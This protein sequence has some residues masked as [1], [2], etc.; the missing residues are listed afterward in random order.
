[1]VY[2][3]GAETLPTLE[4]ME[5][6]LHGARFVECGASQELSVGW[7]APRGEARG[8]LVESV[9]G[10]RILKFMVES[11]S[12]PSN[13]VPRKADE[14]I[15]RILGSEGFISALVV[16]DLGSGKVVAG[17]EIHARGFADETKAFDAVIG[18]IE[19]AVQDAALNGVADAHQIQQRIRRIVGKWV[20]DEYR[21][22]P[23]IIPVVVEV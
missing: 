23:M 14:E 3:L 12:V 19:E 4:A 11:K 2:R 10:Q 7:T 22:R 13:V 5:E 6:A 21:R 9:A 17:P 16:V 1:M 20:S 15:P 18:R 8:A